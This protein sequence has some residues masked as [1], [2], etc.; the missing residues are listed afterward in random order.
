MII[1]LNEILRL[2]REW[3]RDGYS[4]TKTFE[5]NLAQTETWLKKKE[6]GHY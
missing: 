6:K 5:T 4:F 1:L 3:G 2:I